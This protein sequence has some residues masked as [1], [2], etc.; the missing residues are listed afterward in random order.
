[1][2]LTLRQLIEKVYVEMKAREGKKRCCGYRARMKRRTHNLYMTLQRERASGKSEI[3]R[4]SGAVMRSLPVGSLCRGSTDC[5]ASCDSMT[6]FCACR[7]NTSPASVR[8]RRR[9]VRCSNCTPS[10]FS[11]CETCLL[12]T[13]LDIPSASAAAVKLP[14]SMTA[15]NTSI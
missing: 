2:P 15:A 11:S 14:W 9:V 7:A 12:T 3:A 1:M 4:L 5:T 10:C 6:I 8:C 13:G